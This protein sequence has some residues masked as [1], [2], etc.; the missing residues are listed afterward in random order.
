MFKEPSAKMFEKLKAYK[1]YAN[2]CVFFKYIIDEKDINE[3]ES[4]TVPDDT[5]TFKPE[6]THQIFGDDEVIFGYKSLRVDYYLTPGLLHAYI[7][8]S[9]KEK[10]TPR[11]FDGIDPDDVYG[12][13]SNFGCSPGFT[14]NIDSFCSEKLKQD[15]EF[16]PFGVKCHEYSRE[17]LKQSPTNSVFEIYRVDSSLPEYETEKFMDYIDR[18]QTM[19]VFYIE[20]SNFIDT[21]DP[22]WVHYLLYEKR[23]DSTGDIRY[24]T[25]GYL[26]AYNYYA[27]PDNVRTRVSQSL[28]L[29]PYQRLGHGAELLECVFREA[30]LDPRVVDVT[31]EGPSPDF[32]RLRDFATTKMCLTL[33]AFKN[34]DHLKK[35]FNNDMVSEPLKKFKIPKSQS[36]RCY[37]IIRMAHT[38]QN[39]VGDW[40]EF[41]LDVKKR[42]YKP[43]LSMAKFARGGGAGQG[44]SKPETSKM[45]PPPPPPPAL[46]TKTK[47]ASL[48]NRFG[49]ASKMIEEEEEDGVTQIGFGAPSRPSTTVTPSV[50]FTSKNSLPASRNKVSFSNKVTSL[51]TSNST[52]DEESDDEDSAPSTE[53]KASLFITEKE[54]KEYL[55]EQFNEAVS[56]YGKTIKRLEQFNILVK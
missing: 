56:D 7:G 12:A 35:G 10:I 25:A 34:V 33:D 45:P 4:K 16:R 15:R 3:S 51:N 31:C 50:S 30:S 5:K 14:K 28:I 24:M 27:Y 41:R 40:R 37:E 43:F 47:T 21:E 49:G 9:Y 11:R 2:D 19:L 55:E 46:A 1:N 48:F 13:L 44:E 23:K 53:I 39:S 29:P 38:N 26:S 22:Q 6:F 32:V 52:T 17:N 20:T 8:L 42:F 18:V 36:R 54:R